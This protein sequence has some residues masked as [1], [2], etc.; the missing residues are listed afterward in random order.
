M[1]NKGELC[2]ISVNVSSYIIDILV[3]GSFHSVCLFRIKQEIN[4]GI[5]AG[6]LG[7]LSL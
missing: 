3:L 6:T 1:S 2:G 7:F 5:K 4:I